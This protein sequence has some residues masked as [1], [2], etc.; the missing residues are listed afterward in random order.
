MKGGVAPARIV[1]PITGFCS[2]STAAIAFCRP[3]EP[4]SLAPV[5]LR[6]QKTACPLQAAD[7][8][9]CRGCP[10][11]FTAAINVSK[12]TRFSTRLML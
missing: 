4:L 3:P 6:R 9:A 8:V 11:A 12:L 5:G 7:I 10:I 2:L 1:V